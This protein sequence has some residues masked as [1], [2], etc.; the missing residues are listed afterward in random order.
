MT[1]GAKALSDR[2]PEQDPGDPRSQ[3]SMAAEIRIASGK[4]SW[5]SRVFASRV[6]IQAKGESEAVTRSPRRAPGAGPPWP[7]LQAAWATWASPGL[8]LPAPWLFWCKRFLV[9]FWEFSEQ[10]HFWT[11]SALQRQN[12]QNWHW[13]LYQ[14]VSPINDSK[15]WQ[16]DV[17][18]TQNEHG[19]SKNYRY[20]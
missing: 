6:K 19:T 14:Q 13:A 12:R 5:I 9:I 17:A 4:M 16:K 20:V 11:F 15:A 7:R 2:V 10:L 3:V 18:M 1:P 8:H